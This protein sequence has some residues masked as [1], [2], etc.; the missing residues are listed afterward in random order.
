[1]VAKAFNGLNGLRMEKMMNA[2]WTH[3]DVCASAFVFTHESKSLCELGDP[4][5]FIKYG[6]ERCKKLGIEDDEEV[7]I[8]LCQAFQGDV[9]AWYDSLT[10]SV[11]T[12]WFLVKHALLE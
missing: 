5:E 10:K 2:F 7:A 4:L 12:N 6:E 9:R 8:F 11:H 3:L 1:M